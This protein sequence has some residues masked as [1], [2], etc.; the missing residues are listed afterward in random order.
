MSKLK[1]AANTMLA[2]RCSAALPALL[3]AGTAL[4]QDAVP[5]D[6]DRADNS[7]IVVTGTL[8]RGQ[9]PT[10]S[11]LKAVTA[12][13][14][15][16]LGVSDTSQLLGSIPSDSNFNSRPQV[17]S[18]GQYQTVNAPILRYLGGGA[19]G[20]NS[21]LLLLNGHRL[22]GMGVTQT[23]AD[24]DAIPR[25]AIERIDLVPDG[26]SATYGADAVGG[27]VN[28]VTRKRYDGLEVGGHFGKAADYTQWDVDVLAGKKW[29]NGSLWATYNY[30]HHS[31]IRNIDRDYSRDIDYSTNPPSF[32]S[33]NCSPGN[34]QAGGL[35][36]GPQYPGGFAFLPITNYP[37]ING[38][39]VTGAANRCDASDNG[40]FLP[41]ESRH[42]AMAGLDVDLSDSINF[43]VTAF[44]TNRQSRSDGGPVAYNLTSAYPGLPNGTVYGNLRP[45]F[46]QN[47]YGYTSLETWGVTP[48][49]TVKLG[50]DWQVVASY[51][52][53]EGF[54]KFYSNG[55][56][57][58]ALQA[59][60]NN[61]AFNAFAGLFASTPAG[62]TALAYQS[63][64]RS[65]SSGKDQIS[66]GRV[67]ADGPLFALPG[68]D[69]RAA[70]GGEIYN[71]RFT[72]RNGSAIETNLQ[73]ILPYSASRTVKSAFGELSIPLFSEDNSAPGFHSLTLSAAGRYD[74]Y[75]DFGG[76][77]NPKFGI[78]WKPTSWWTLRG[79]WGKSYQAPSLSSK[80]EVIPTALQVFPANTFGASGNTAGK[81]ILLLYPG[82]GVNLQ[83]QKATTWQIGTDFKPEFIP[84]LSASMT[85]YNIDFRDRIAFPSFFTPAFYNLFPNSYILN[86]AANPLT[87]AQIQS[88]V[89]SVSPTLLAAA[90]IQTY[91]NDPSKVY[92]LENGL[93]QN[94]SRV[95]TSGLDFSVD[96]QHTT[97]FG[98]VFAG[99]AGTY[100]LS[101]EGQASVASPVQGLDANQVIRW[102]TST[103]VGAT[104]GDFLG[105]LTWNR[106]GG[107]EIPPTAM[108]NNQSRVAPFN[109]F[110]LALQYAPKADGYMHDVTFTLNVDN[111]FDTDPPVL[112]GSNGGAFGYSGFTLGRFV[113]LG[114]RKK[115]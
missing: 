53:G 38:A 51:N 75:S 61:G 111:L 15:S 70:I 100:I 80:A 109:I 82:G 76:T 81:F 18:F 22:P 114:V 95:K 115:F 13:D 113:Q 2:L 50:R 106:T 39:P 110:N 6:A 17:G 64:Y 42:S 92:A 7:D 77:F 78:T 25:S 16:Q 69:V 102:R 32:K 26:G 10:G 86:T 54:A 30:A 47:N 96:Y 112:N 27:V 23:S 14:I 40:T 29:D 67:V 36:I 90:N 19:S 1:I 46:G 4:A 108:N 28:L 34:Y 41:E 103:V 97:G 37:I 57:Q 62:Q 56:D 84:G 101:Y 8:I 33:L 85:Y 74:N 5:A 44:Y 98:S 52:Y 59:Q 66:N 99:V 24:I 79:N 104:V 45:T 68:G 12:E 63:A 21:T 20:S 91:L 105:R 31:L 65:L 58:S 107:Y 11:D 60:A 55:I 83:P 89:S 94:L 88:Y 93:S 71:E 49:F 43:N 73:S 87:A 48:Q 35:V 9:A 3:I 72:Q